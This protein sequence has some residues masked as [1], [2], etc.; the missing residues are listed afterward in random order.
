[1]CQTLSWITLLHVN[2]G[3]GFT[4][5][6][7]VS[8]SRHLCLEQ[9]EGDW[10]PLLA[11]CLC[12]ITLLC[13]GLFTISSGHA[14]LVMETGWTWAMG[15]VVSCWGKVAPVVSLLPSGKPFVGTR[16]SFMWFKISVEKSLENKWLCCYHIYLSNYICLSN[17]ILDKQ[18]W[19]DHRGSRYWTF[20]ISWWGLYSR[21]NS[22]F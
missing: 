14:H 19:V 15:N 1:M 17:L 22:I 6:C 5:R 3:P 12:F 7:L 21:C 16:K 8:E 10:R 11:W 2:P 9:M 13:R 18:K 4:L 20:R